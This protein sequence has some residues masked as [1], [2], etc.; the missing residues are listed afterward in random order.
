MTKADKIEL[1]KMQHICPNA[2][3]IWLIWN[4]GKWV[5]TLW[6]HW[7]YKENRCKLCEKNK[8]DSS[9]AEWVGKGS[10]KMICELCKSKNTRVE[11]CRC[12]IPSMLIC[13]DCKAVGNSGIP[14]S[15]EY[16]YM[17]YEEAKE[18][19]DLKA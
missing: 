14:H 8:S 9:F 4:Y 7:A 13:E 6:P 1:R 15:R 2:V 11:K 16:S 17:S 18:K 10:K 3:R 5:E 19:L 12:G